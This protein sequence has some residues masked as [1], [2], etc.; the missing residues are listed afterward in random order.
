MYA[1]MD[2]R[3]S[4]ESRRS[5]NVDTDD[6]YLLSDSLEYTGMY[7]CMRSLRCEWPW[8]S[9]QYHAKDFTLPCGYRFTVVGLC[10]MDGMFKAVHNT[11]SGP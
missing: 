2:A 5:T 8:N 10:H 4:I 3:M 9:S 1:G 6:D 7:K 11:T